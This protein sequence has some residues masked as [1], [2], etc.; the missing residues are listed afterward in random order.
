MKYIVWG[1]VAIAALYF[2]KSLL[3][4]SAPSAHQV[5]PLVRD[6]L[7]TQ[8]GPCTIKHLSDVSVGKYAA[9]MGGWPIY[10]SHE[11]TCR[12]GTQSATFSQSTTY[13]GL[14][15]ARKGVAVAFAR[16]TSSGGVEL[17]VPAIF[18]QGQQDMNRAL[19]SAFDNV[20]VR[21]GS[22]SDAPPNR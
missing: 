8:N 13:Q 7:E 5:E 17:F 16:K 12:G 19:Q 3:G 10:A 9:Q 6:F 22:G 11:E 14:D 2:G 20:Q 21:V 4:P 18:Q 1:A 15:D